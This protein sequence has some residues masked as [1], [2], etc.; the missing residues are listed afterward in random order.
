MTLNESIRT[1]CVGEPGET[2]VT[3]SVASRAFDAF[4]FQFE[5][6]AGRCRPALPRALRKIRKE[7]SRLLKTFITSPRKIVTRI[8]HADCL[9][10]FSPPRH[11]IAARFLG[12][13]LLILLAFVASSAQAF[14]GSVTSVQLTNYT[15]MAVEPAGNH[16]Q[17]AE[18]D[19]TVSNPAGSTQFAN[20]SVR[21][22]ILDSTGNPISITTETGSV[23][24]SIEYH[25]VSASSWRPG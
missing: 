21:F 5:S 13:V 6:G 15:G 17:Q 7:F 2:M 24:P 14:T 18:G 10:K 9:M 25:S 23:G 8:G 11:G 1:L 16:A 20:M 22:R 4:Q 3:V 19:Y 12:W